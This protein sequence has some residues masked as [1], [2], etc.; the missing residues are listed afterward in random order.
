M[1]FPE[2][3]LKE[4]LKS[5]NI[6]LNW[7]DPETSVLEGIFARGDR[8]LGKVILKAY[9]LGCKLDGWSECFSFSKWMEAFRLC[10][11]DP[12]FYSER[13]RDVS[14]ILPWET[15]SCGVTKEFFIS[16]YEKARMA[17]TSPNYAEKC[18]NCGANKF[19]CN[20]ICQEKR[21]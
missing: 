15:V 18:L 20:S 10:G 7:H 2:S 14:E 3:L 1:G 9:E 21:K 6:R 8:K 13:E 12:K 16:E 17:Q 4:N 19:K 11:I 5:K